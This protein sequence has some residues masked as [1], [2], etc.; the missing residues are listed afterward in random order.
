MLRRLVSH[1]AAYALAAGGASALSLV[2]VPLFARLLEPSD[3]GVLGVLG[4]S[5]GALGAIVGLNPHLYVTARLGGAARDRVR[6]VLGAVVISCLVTGLLALPLVWLLPKLVPTLALP[7]WVLP[8]LVLVA[9]LSSLRGAHLALERLEARVRSVMVLQ[10]GAT[11]LEL[12]VGLLIL[13]TLGL[14]WKARILGTVI[15][16]V[17]SAVVAAFLLARSGRLALRASRAELRDFVT[18]SLPL[19]P[20]ALAFWALGAADRYLVTSY[21]GVEQTGYY[22]LAYRLC[23]VFPLLSSSVLAAFTPLFYRP[24]HDSQARRDIVRFSYLYVAGTTLVALLF[25]VS[26]PLLVPWLLGEAYRPTLAHLPWLAGAYVFGAVRDLAA[27]YLY[28][29]SRTGLLASLTAGAALLNLA[30]N[31][32]LLPRV[33]AVGAAVA[34]TAAFAALALATSIAAVRL[35]PMPWFDSLGGRPRGS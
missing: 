3:F 21:C 14:G 32:L 26:A 33:G 18:F 29:A 17:A 2:T 10:L 30:L 19:M 4:A 11:A 1:S 34:T 35:H 22:S 13:V 23:A 27:G 7:M 8:A 6:G 31:F 16:A 9:G 12:A 25:V 24:E 28:R 15:A 5:L 20:H